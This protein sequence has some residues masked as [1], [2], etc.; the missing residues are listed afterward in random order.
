M[1]YILENKGR[2]TSQDIYRQT[3]TRVSDYKIQEQID[4]EVD[5]R[6][7]RGFD[8]PEFVTVDVDDGKT[9]YLKKGGDNETLS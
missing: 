9:V 5:E 7:H 6:R 8:S 4:K 1:K 2:C 3:R